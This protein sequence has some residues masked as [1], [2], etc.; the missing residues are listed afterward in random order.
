ML[1][2]PPI[3]RAAD[4]MYRTDRWEQGEIQTGSTVS[5]L[6]GT[7]SLPVNNP[8]GFR[9]G[10]SV[11]RFMHRE[12]PHEEFKHTERILHPVTAAAAVSSPAMSAAQSN[13]YTSPFAWL[14]SYTTR[15]LQRPIL[16][17]QPPESWNVDQTDDGM[18]DMSSVVTDWVVD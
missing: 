12:M 9:I 11:K 2:A 15:N 3:G 8:D 6:R 7:N 13:R 5:A 10:W 17:R 18:A 4:E 1:Y 14:S 16:R